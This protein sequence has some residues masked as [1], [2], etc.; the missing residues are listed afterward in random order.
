VAGH[1]AP[2]V[3]WLCLGLGCMSSL[4][5]GASALGLKARAVLGTAG[6]VAAVLLARLLRG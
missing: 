5:L 4:A 2:V 1:L 6:V 3:K